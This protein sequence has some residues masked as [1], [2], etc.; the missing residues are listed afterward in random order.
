MPEMFE[1]DRSLIPAFTSG[2][3]KSLMAHRMAKLLPRVCLTLL[4]ASQV[5]PKLRRRSKLSLLPQKLPRKSMLKPR[6]PEPLNP[7]PANPPP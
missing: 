3:T 5:R 7:D 6:C 4:A 2:S 1:L